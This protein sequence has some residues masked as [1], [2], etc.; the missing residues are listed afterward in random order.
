MPVGATRGSPLAKCAF[1]LTSQRVP[2][3]Q[4]ITCTQP[5]QGALAI[6]LI[7]RI[8]K[9]DPRGLTVTAAGHDFFPAG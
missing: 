9:P 6:K 7:A 1:V 4:C 5:L 8:I 3:G 2:Y